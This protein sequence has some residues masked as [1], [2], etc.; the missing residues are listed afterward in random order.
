MRHPAELHTWVLSAQ[1][2]KAYLPEA[3]PSLCQSGSRCACSPE[4]RGYLCSPRPPGLLALFLGHHS[5]V[6]YKPDLVYAG[7][8]GSPRAEQGKG[9]GRGT[10]WLLQRDPSRW[11][12]GWK[13][14]DQPRGSALKSRPMEGQRL[15]LSV[16]TCR[17]NCIRTWDDFCSGSK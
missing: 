16:R 8:H 2:Q 7:Q 13:P 12:D 14:Q 3:T 11:A 9:A 6:P 17:G 10:S 1:T 5:P 4:E 15:Y